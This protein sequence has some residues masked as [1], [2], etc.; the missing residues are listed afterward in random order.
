LSDVFEV[1]ARIATQVARS[2]E[3][4]LGAEQQK[5]LEQRP[6]SSLVA[7]DAYLKGLEIFSK[8]FSTSIDREAAAQFERAVA[9]DPKF[10]MAW[11]YLSL[12]QSM[13][14][15]WGQPTGDVGDTAGEAA[16]KAMAL[17]PTLP[18]AYMALGVYERVVRHDPAH[19]S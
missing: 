5:E 3:V 19:A 12:S 6:T 2:L 4:A 18:K 7:Y 14:Y 13:R 9:L 17:S 1:Q 15:S 11:A 16:E 10:A 8:G